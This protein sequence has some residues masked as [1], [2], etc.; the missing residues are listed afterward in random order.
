VRRC[1]G[2]RIREY[3]QRRLLRSIAYERFEHSRR[4]T[5]AAATRI[6]LCVRDYDGARCLVTDSYRL[7][8]GLVRCQQWFRERILHVDYVASQRVCCRVDRRL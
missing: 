8:Y 6:V 5:G 7:A 1:G 2:L 3:A 4:I